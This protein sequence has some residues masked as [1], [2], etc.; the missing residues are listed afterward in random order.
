VVC[1]VPRR[2]LHEEPTKRFPLVTLITLDE[3]TKREAELRGRFANDPVKQ[4]RML[5]LL[6]EGVRQMAVDAQRR[7]VLP[8]HFVEHIGVDRDLYFI[9]SNDSVQIWHPDHYLA[10]RGEAAEGADGTLDAL[11]F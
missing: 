2:A 3:L 7:V 10:W 11:L 1:G 9:C 4:F 5:Q 6:N 8:S